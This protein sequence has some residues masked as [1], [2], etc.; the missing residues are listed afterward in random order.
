[1]HTP[2]GEPDDSRAVRVRVY[3]GRA[4]YD[5]KAIHRAPEG[6]DLTAFLKRGAL[7]A[8]PR[9]A[10]W[11]LVVLSV[12]RT[13][14]GEA[15][16]PMLDRLARRLT[17]TAPP[18]TVAALAVAGDGARAVLAVGARDAAWIGRLRTA[19]GGIGR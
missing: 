4:H 1:M 14:A 16:A 9:A 10:G 6:A 13:R 19:L 8:L 2:G 5:A 11:H 7:A 12:E 15:L 18:D 3:R 17:R